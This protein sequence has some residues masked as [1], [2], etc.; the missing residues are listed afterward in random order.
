MISS[1]S[2][3][4]IMRKLGRIEGIALCEE[5]AFREMLIGNAEEIC[6]ILEAEC[7]PCMDPPRCRLDLIRTLPMR[8]LA[9]YLGREVGA[10]FDWLGWLTESI[11]RKGTG[12]EEKP[13]TP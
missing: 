10:G 13:R 5:E 11:G 12:Y 8:E 6:R 7:R 9:E 1:Q 3:S 4:A 2:Y